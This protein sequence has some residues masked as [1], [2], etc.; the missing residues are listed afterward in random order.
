MRRTLG[1]LTLWTSYVSAWVVPV[2]E[3]ITYIRVKFEPLNKVFWH[4]V[5]ALAPL[6]HMLQLMTQSVFMLLLPMA[7]KGGAA[8]KVR[9]QPYWRGRRTNGG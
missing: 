2:D 5:R 1:L 8:M 4:I 7:R 3:A 9:W 6:G